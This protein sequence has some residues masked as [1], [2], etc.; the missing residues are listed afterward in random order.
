[1]RKNAKIAAVLAA[2]GL[3]VWWYRQ[4]GASASNA[5]STVDNE[6]GGVASLGDGMINVAYQIGAAIMP[7]GMEISLAGLNHLK[8]V[9]GYRSTVYKDVAGFKTIGYGH[10]LTALENYT[11]ITREEA[12]RLLAKDV[13]GAEAGVN[14]LVTVPLKQG[15]F[16]ALVSFAYNVGVG[17]FRRSTMLKNLNA[18]SYTG[19]AAEFG[20]WIYAGGK[21]SGGLQNRRAA[22]LALFNGN[23]QVSA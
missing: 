13:A 12:A 14:A 3:F 17:A 15:Q 21:P 2:T 19:A 1:M 9:E 20:K 16:D 5:V 22:E 10:K 23:Q 7:G 6:A 11:E 8:T 4:Q 18:G